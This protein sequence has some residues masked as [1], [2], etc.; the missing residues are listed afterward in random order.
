M[1]A[2]KHLFSTLMKIAGLLAVLAG[3]FVGF[4]ELWL[5]YAEQQLIDGL[6]TLSKGGST[7]RTGPSCPVG[8]VEGVQVRFVSGTEY[9][10]E[11][12]CAES[13][14]TIEQKKGTLPRF[15]QKAPGSAGVIAKDPD[16]DGSAI[17]LTL[18]GR[19]KTVLYGSAD[20][21]T[22]QSPASVCSG[23]GFVCCNPLEEAG[24]G[25]APPAPATDCPNECFRSCR[26][27]PLI[28]GF[29]TDPPIELT[30]RVVEL[31]GSSPEVLFSYVVQDLDDKIQQVTIDFGDGSAKSSSKDADSI[32]HR[33]VCSSPPCQFTATLRATDSM[34][35]ESV[36]SG[37]SRIEVMVR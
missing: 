19:T 10:Y 36:A 2:L 22:W 13:S 29:R 37:I 34:G 6:N 1:E 5:I 9:V 28:L 12:R 16:V 18:W 31:R 3:L 32:Q 30:S 8:G 15:V 21:E 35:N 25:G 11:W 17:R 33:Y 20:P 14:T 7:R 23:F 4:R 27:R 26:Q 24:A